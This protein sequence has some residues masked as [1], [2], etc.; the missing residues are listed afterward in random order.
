LGVAV[1]E[2]GKG[3]REA[4]CTRRGKRAHCNRPD[5]GIV[6]D[7]LS[8]NGSSRGEEEERFCFTQRGKKVLSLTRRMQEFLGELR[9]AHRHTKREKKKQCH[10]AVIDRGKWMPDCD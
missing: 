10:T 1:V 5:P 3:E 8:R 6:G 4:V 7:F 9:T 2:K